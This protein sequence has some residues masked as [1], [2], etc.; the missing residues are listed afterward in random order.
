M[1]YC[2]C[3]TEKEAFHPWKRKNQHFWVIKAN[4]FSWMKMKIWP[5]Y[6]CFSFCTVKL[7]L[8]DEYDRIWSFMP[9]GSFPMV[10][11]YIN[12]SHILYM[13]HGNKD[14]I[15]F[16]LKHGKVEIDILRKNNDIETLSF[17]QINIMPELLMYMMTLF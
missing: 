9:I 16:D 7:F 12:E 17:I 14:L 13:L 5:K 1:G 2:H 11:N 3:G 4:F 10:R 8:L 15:W 6:I